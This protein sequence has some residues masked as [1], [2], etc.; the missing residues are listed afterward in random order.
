VWREQ[1]EYDRLADKAEQKILT[2]EE[3]A[4][5]LVLIKQLRGWDLKKL[6]TAI[7]L[8]KMW[9]MKLDETIQVLEATLITRPLLERPKIESLSY[10]DSS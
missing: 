8:S 5:L 3:Q 2:D 4:R 10:R 1:E 7:Q 6:Q 9:E